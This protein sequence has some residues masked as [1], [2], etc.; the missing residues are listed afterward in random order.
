MNRSTRI[1]FIVI[2]LLVLI[3][4]GI[5]APFPGKSRIPV[6][7]GCRIL[8]GIDLA[9]GAE[10]RYKVLFK[11]GQR[12]DR[13]QATQLAADVLRRRLEGRQL[14]ESKLTTSGDEEII[15]Q[16]PGVD[17]EG[18]NEIKRTIVGVGKLELYAV[19]SP[20]LQD[21][22][23][24][25]RVVPA[26]YKAIRARGPSPLLVLETPVIDGRHILRAEPQQEPASGGLRWVTVA[27]LDAEGARRF[28][29]AAQ[30]LYS[31][32][33]RIAIV[34]DDEVRSAPVV[35]SPSFHGRLRISS[36]PE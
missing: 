13:K 11:D 34:L 16:L 12:D 15:L 18:L 36:A 24:R 3:A 25:D 6:L 29:E 8:P 33:G 7:S 10:L 23:E 9:G 17:E 32:R 28:D 21:Q 27:D 26:G 31:R 22:F 19:A 4:V 2:L 5:A 1:Q 20:A 35:R 30:R 14:R